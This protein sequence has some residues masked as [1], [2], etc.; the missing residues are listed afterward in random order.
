MAACDRFD[1]VVVPFPFVEAPTAKRRPA[2]SLARASFVQA[3]GQGIFAMITS[4]R[5]SRWP[6]D[7][8]LA[9]PAEPGLTAASVIRWKLFTLPEPL[10]ERRLGRLSAG[11][12]TRAARALQEILAD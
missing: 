1:V 10:V 12:Q 3:H 6:S 9:D 2:L 7:L 11:D 4:A 5:H 8:E